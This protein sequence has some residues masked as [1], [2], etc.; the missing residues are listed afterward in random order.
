MIGTNKKRVYLAVAV[1]VIVIAITIVLKALS[2]KA[3]NIKSP[4]NSVQASSSQNV[5]KSVQPA[6]T[7]S[8]GGNSTN[9]SKT[10]DSG[11]TA[12]IVRA[13]KF[14]SEIFSGLSNQELYVNYSVD[15]KQW[16]YS[17]TSVLF[18]KY[19]NITR[20]TTR[21]L[22]QNNTSF[23]IYLQNGSSA[24]GCAPQYIPAATGKGYFNFSNITCTAVQT[25]PHN[26]PASY[27]ES[28]F[29]FINLPSNAIITIYKSSQSSYNYMLC[30]L[31]NGSISGI[32]GGLSTNFTICIS[33][34]YNI[35]VYMSLPYAKLDI[36]EIA[37]GNVTNSLI[38][39]L[40]GRVV[41]ATP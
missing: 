23:I 38:G 13:S 37:I 31:I 20:I 41:N 36:R 39:E 2:S 12:V 33:S 10:I 19:G 7:S 34:A 21:N 8:L 32:S 30:N 35:P 17:N 14:N 28:Y 15:F 25:N 26:S 1:I 11:V 16:P 22:V 24:Y 27:L 6:S 9:A 3:G 18:E 4:I 40:P 29:G 5:S